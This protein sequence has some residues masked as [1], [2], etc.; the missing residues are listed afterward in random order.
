[1]EQNSAT[2]TTKPAPTKSFDHSALTKDVLTSLLSNLNSIE[3]LKDQIIKS[4][5]NL[6][7]QIEE[8]TANIIELT[9]TVKDTVEEHE[10]YT[11]KVEQLE[12]SKSQLNNEVNNLKKI[13]MEKQH[14]HPQP[15]ENTNQTVH[16]FTP[17]F[18]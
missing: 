15:G 1:M 5:E 7:K 8:N 3:I 14:P 10:K 2:S 4:Q 17:K 6:E 12:N 16:K 11:A 13:L 18:P 9:Q